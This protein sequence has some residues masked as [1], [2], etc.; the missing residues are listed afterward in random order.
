MK[1]TRVQTGAL[2][3]KPL[4]ANPKM[5]R[6]ECYQGRQ[7]FHVAP[8]VQQL[9]SAATTLVDIRNSLRTATHQSRIYYHYSAAQ[10]LLGSRE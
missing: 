8:A 3:E 6:I 4:T 10:G 2:A 7:Q 9:C 1:Y 5:C